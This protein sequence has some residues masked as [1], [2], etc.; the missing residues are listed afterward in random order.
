M[1]WSIINMTL[2]HGLDIAVKEINDRVTQSQDS[3][4]KSAMNYKYATV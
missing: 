4:K 1:L 2:L 3:W